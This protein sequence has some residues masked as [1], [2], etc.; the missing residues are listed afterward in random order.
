M[1]RVTHLFVCAIN[2]L[3]SPK[4]NLLFPSKK[5]KDKHFNFKTT[6]NTWQSHSL[7]PLLNDFTQQKKLS[8]P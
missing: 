6:L 8:S 7:L 4:G 1:S 5:S 2:Y 3:C